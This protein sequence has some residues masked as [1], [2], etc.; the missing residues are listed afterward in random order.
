M[1]Q[2][3]KGMALGIVMTVVAGALIGGTAHAEWFNSRAPGSDSSTLKSIASSLQGIERQLGELVE[4]QK[5][6]LRNKNNE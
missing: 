6:L 3:I 1:K 2:T 4:V 5:E